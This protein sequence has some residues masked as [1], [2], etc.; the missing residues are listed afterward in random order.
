MDPYN[1]IQAGRFFK[2]AEMHYRLLEPFRNLIYGLSEEYAGSNYGQPTPRHETLVPLM[3]QTVDAYMMG[4]V[5]NR[6][7]VILSTRRPDLEGFC[8]HFQVAVNNMIEE[9]ELEETLRR[10]VLDAFFCVG[11]LKVHLKDGHLIDIGA[12]EPIDPGQPG[13]SNVSLFNFVYDMSATRWRDIRYAADSYRVTMDYLRSNRGFDQDVVKD[14]LPTSKFYLDQQQLNN[15]SKGS[16]TDPDEIEPSTDLMDVWFPQEKLIV[17]W[18]MDSATRFR[19]KG[20][21][22]AVMP[23]DDLQVYHLLGFDDVPENIM[24][25]SPASHLASMARLVNNLFRKQSKRARAQR[26]VH[27]YA[28]SAKN[29]AG[30]AKNAIDDEFIESPDPKEIGE[31]KIGGVD[32]NLQAYAEGLIGLYDRMAGNLTAMLGLGA[33]AETLGQEQLIHGAVSKKE[34]KMIYRVTD[35]TRRVVRDLSR[36][37]WNDAAKVIPGVIVPHGAEDYPIDATW[38]PGNREGEFPE[39]DINIDVFS[40]A[41]QSPSSRVQTINNILSSIYVPLMPSIEQQGGSIDM[42]ELNE[43]YVDLLGEPRFNKL[44]SFS[45]TPPPEVEP[46]DGTPDVPVQPPNTR[47]ES[48]RRSFGGSPQSQQVMKQQAWLARGQGTANNG[49]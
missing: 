4:L 26:Q 17:T 47:H 20:K 36:M 14:V 18:A 43:I 41:Y 28:P 46:P 32:A 33:Q 15:I 10:W 44:L 31:I 19:G 38:T 42:R 8:S 34:A 12:G 40:M 7:R 9:V 37:L 1:E 30:R 45:S 49:G 5:A 25:T 11:V 35:G 2:T 21:P 13:V 29:V 23:D 39:Y 22:L 24:P 27:T 16:E 6:P 48:V 3:N